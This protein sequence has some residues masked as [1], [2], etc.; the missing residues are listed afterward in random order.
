MR[1]LERAGEG[2]WEAEVRVLK[3]R[4]ASS[5]LLERREEWRED[6]RADLEEEE[7]SRVRVLGLVLGGGGLG[8]RVLGRRGKI[9]GWRKE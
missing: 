9:E 1:E 2:R 4:H 8:F 3:E 5:V 7:E 6:S